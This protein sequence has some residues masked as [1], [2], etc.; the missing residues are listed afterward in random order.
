MAFPLC[1][2]DSITR[3]PRWGCCYVDS[4]HVENFLKTRGLFSKLWAR[5]VIDCIAAPNLYGYQNRTPLILG[6]YPHMF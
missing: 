6:S 1:G 3:V 5:L 2:V 4:W